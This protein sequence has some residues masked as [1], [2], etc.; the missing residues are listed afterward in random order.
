MT[1]R[2]INPLT[3]LQHKAAF[4]LYCVLSEL[5]VLVGCSIPKSLAPIV[6]AAQPSPVAVVQ[7]SRGRISMRP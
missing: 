3:S 1:A 6:V 2:G 4:T 7:L 5:Q